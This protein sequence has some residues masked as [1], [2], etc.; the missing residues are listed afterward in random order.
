MYV[1]QD[2]PENVTIKN[3]GRKG[4]IVLESQIFKLAATQ[5]IW[6]VLFLVLLYYILKSQEKRDRRQEERE[7]KY[8]ELTQNL[9][10]K[11]DVV[12]DIQDNVAGIKQSLKQ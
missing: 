11:F 7:E 4:G 1:V 9:V 2:W 6:A 10:N 12:K 8:Q 5:G 3:Q